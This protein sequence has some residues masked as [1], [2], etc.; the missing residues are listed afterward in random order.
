MRSR[1]PWISRR[2]LRRD[3]VERERER[4]RKDAAVP[5]LPE[6]ELAARNLRRWAVGH[7]VRGVDAVASPV[8]RPAGP[9]ALR[10]LV[11]ARV[12][13]VDRIGKNLLLTLKRGRAPVGVWSHLGM[14]GKWLRRGR[15]AEPPRFSRVRLALDDGATLHYCDMRLFGRFRVVPDARWTDVPTIAELGPDPLRDGVDA[16]RLHERLSRLRLPIK[17]ALL[18]QRLLAGVGNIQASESLFRARLDP[19]RPAQSLTR[20]ETGRLARAIFASIAY[21]LARFADA[22]ADTDEADVVYVEESR[23]KNPFKVYDRAGQRCPRGNGEIV[24]IVQAQRSTF[25]CPA[26]VLAAQK[27]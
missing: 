7:K 6:V 10:V 11:G 15:G 9:A 8:L 17:V 20:V 1:R 5:E 18:D 23:T 16:A 3:G 25:F 26:C 21:T 22:G 4:R 24:R 14:T 27:G 2:R 12:A 19:R 13:G